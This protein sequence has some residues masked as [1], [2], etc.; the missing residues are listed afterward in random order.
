VGTLSV[1]LNWR[2]IFV[3]MKAD[4]IYASA[5]F[6]VEAARRATN[7]IPIVFSTHGDPV[8]ARACSERAR[9][10]EGDIPKREPHRFLSDATNPLAPT[11]MKPIEEQ[12]S[13]MG[14]RVDQV[15]VQRV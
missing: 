9:N 2:L 4:V 8:G 3:R 10:F 14:L 5:S 11:I 15:L 1:W 12:A 7:T 13:K 6:H